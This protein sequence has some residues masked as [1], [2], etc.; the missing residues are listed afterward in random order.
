MTRP[1]PPIR[2]G[3]KRRSRKNKRIT[4]GLSWTKRSFRKRGLLGFLIDSLGIDDSQEIREKSM[5]RKE[6]EPLDDGDSRTNGEEFLVRKGFGLSRPRLGGDSDSL[7]PDLQKDIFS[8]RPH[9]PSLRK[10]THKRP[11]PSKRIFSPN[12][13]RIRPPVR[14][15]P[16]LNRRPKK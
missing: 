2:K 7:T 6:G 9:S 12:K 11:S 16:V 8:I 4:P 1:F 15:A 5:K 10:E 13:M 14:S 3:R